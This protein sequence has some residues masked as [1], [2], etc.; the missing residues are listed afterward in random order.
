M[1]G[2]LVHESGLHSYGSCDFSANIHLSKLLVASSEKKDNVY[3]CYHDEVLV[4]TNG[5]I[6]VQAGSN[7][8]Q[9]LRVY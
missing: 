4:V 6:K 3:F 1:Y 7:S 5:S 8:C 9:S 2:G